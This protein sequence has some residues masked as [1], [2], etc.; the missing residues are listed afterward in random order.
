MKKLLSL[1]SSLGQAIK[2]KPAIAS[3]I[4]VVVVAV[5]G[6]FGLDLDATQLTA[7][8]SVAAVITAGLTHVTTSPAGKHEDTPREEHP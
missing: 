4:A 2:A 7:A 1:L 5:G 8:I 6:R 3:G